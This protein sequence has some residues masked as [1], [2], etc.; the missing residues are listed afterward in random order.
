[1]TTHNAAFDAHS[2][3]PYRPGSRKNVPGDAKARQLI[4][5]HTKLPESCPHYLDLRR[6]FENA[7]PAL[8]LSKTAEQLWLRLF[9]HTN[10]VDWVDGNVVLVWP[11]NEELMSKLRIS[12]KTLKNAFLQLRKVGLLGFKDSPT[13]VRYGR[14]NKDRTIDQ[15]NSYGIIMN[16]ILGLYENFRQLAEDIAVA[17]RY[18]RQ[19]R[20]GW[21]SAKREGE[22]LLTRAWEIMPAEECQTFEAE[23]G[24]LKA[25]FSASGRDFELKEALIDELKGLNQTIQSEIAGSEGFATEDTARAFS[26]AEIERMKNYVLKRTSAEGKNNPPIRTITTASAGISNRLSDEGGRRTGGIQG[27]LDRIRANGQSHQAESVHVYETRPL[28]FDQVKA[29]LPL[30]LKREVRDDHGWYQLQDL[31]EE[32]CREYRVRLDT[33]RLAVSTMGRA[34]ACA[35]LTIV[36]AKYDELNKPDNYLASLIHRHRSGQLQL[37]RSLFGILDRAKRKPTPIE[38]LELKELA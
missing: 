32:R 23:F 5:K 38:Q 35:A 6:A 34:E 2:L 9:G 8:G 4:L 18:K 25:Q 29:C 13:K 19:I 3:R 21:T 26:E 1:M 20:Y 24:A 31:L 16:P 22:E 33:F 30:E 15:A 14:R 17:T 7:A 36:I 10:A 28:S 12:L 11:S 37:A 27:R